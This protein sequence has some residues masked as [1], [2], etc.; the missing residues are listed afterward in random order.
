M[1]ESLPPSLWPVVLRSATGKSWPPETRTDAAAFVQQAQWEQLLPLLCDAPDMPPIVHEALMAV[2][3]ASRAHA[4]RAA[5]ITERLRQFTQLMSRLGEE[6]ILL[7]GCD[8]RHRLY[9]QP[10][11]RPVSDIDVLV[12]DGDM[13]RVATILSSAGFTRFY[14]G[15]LSVYSAL[16]H[17]AALGFGTVVVDLHQRF[18]QRHRHT[19]DYRSIWRRAIPVNGDRFR[20]L[21]LSDAD[22]V[23]YLAIS[24]AIKYLR[25]PLIAFVDLWRLLRANPDCANEA[26]RLAQEWQARH[27]FYAMLRRAT[28]LLPEF[29][30]LIGEVRDRVISFPRR[31]LLDRFVIPNDAG[32]QTRMPRLSQLWTKYWLMDNVIRRTRCV[33]EHATESMLGYLHARRVMMRSSNGEAPADGT[34]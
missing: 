21:R 24:M 4:A 28:W 30:G 8:F 17:E 2:R 19:I 7:K 34:A 6:F 15:N 23:T 29:E 16:H 14:V 25:G 13:E 18:G 12:R 3:N 11:H 10:Q 26:A 20:G 9:K 1:A 5:V 22:A 32:F 31:S 27:V 33:A